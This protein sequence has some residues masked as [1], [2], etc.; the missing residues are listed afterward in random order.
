[1]L[2]SLR[3]LH[4]LRKLKSFDGEHT[5]KKII[6]YSNCKIYGFGYFAYAICQSV[7]LLKTFINDY[8]SKFLKPVIQ[9]CLQITVC[10]F[11]FYLGF[12]FTNLHDSQDTGETIS[13]TPLY[14][15]IHFTDT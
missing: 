4:V 3:L 1:M 6:K 7:T 14:Y 11:S 9:K 13:L 2:I 5:C 12:S 8:A 10:Q 15:F